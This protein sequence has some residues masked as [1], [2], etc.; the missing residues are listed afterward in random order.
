MKVDEELICRA[1][2]LGGAS[3]RMVASLVVLYRV[4]ADKRGRLYTRIAESYELDLRRI[5]AQRAR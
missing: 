5:V 2:S 1:Q 4:F 3:S